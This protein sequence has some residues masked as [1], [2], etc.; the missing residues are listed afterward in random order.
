MQRPASGGT[1]MRVLITAPTLATCMQV[2]TV[3]F[4]FM[5]YPK[6]FSSKYALGL[7]AVVCSL[8]AIQELQRRKGGDVKRTGSTVTPL[9]RRR[10]SRAA[11]CTPRGCRRCCAGTSVTCGVLALTGWLVWS[12]LPSQSPIRL[13]PRQFA[14]SQLY[15]QLLQVRSQAARDCM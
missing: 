13:W 12:R 11:C 3:L 6:P 1:S 9:V 14:A 15:N 2:C 8:A 7:L 10:H 4:S 5:L